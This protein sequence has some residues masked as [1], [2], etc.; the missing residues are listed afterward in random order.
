MYHALRG[1]TGVHSHLEHVLQEVE[2]LHGVPN[3]GAVPER[4]V[5]RAQLRRSRVIL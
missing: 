1:E 4:E 2:K 5:W 3:G